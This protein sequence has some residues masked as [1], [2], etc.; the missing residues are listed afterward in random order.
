MCTHTSE[1]ME[2]RKQSFVEG[3]RGGDGGSNKS[4]KIKTV[5]EEKELKE[6][7][8]SSELVARQSANG[9]T[10]RAGRTIRP[11]GIRRWFGR[12]GEENPATLH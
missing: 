9:Q 11:A 10:P 8:S 3:G 4:Q 1:K 7:W 5:R 12:R 2:T 6:I